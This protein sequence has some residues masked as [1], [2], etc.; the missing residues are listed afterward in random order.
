MLENYIS[1][2][3]NKS[4]AS[5]LSLPVY[6]SSYINL[7]SA[8]QFLA[9]SICFQL[10]VENISEKENMLLVWKLRIPCSVGFWHHHS[11][12]ESQ[13]LAQSFHHHTLF[14]VIRSFVLV[15]CSVLDSL[16]CLFILS[17]HSSVNPGLVLFPFSSG[18]RRVYFD[19]QIE[20]VPTVSS[21][22]LIHCCFSPVLWLYPLCAN[23]ENLILLNSVL[24]GKML[25][26]TIL[27]GKSGQEGLFP[28]LFHIVIQEMVYFSSSAENIYWS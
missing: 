13:V 3:I 22:Q 10:L 19:T 14:S 17:L 6:I 12:L 26:T 8:L 11:T 27:G 28:P 16:P 20:S 15:P 9:V 23:P 1:N 7:D 21:K 24:S 18:L 5:E 2:L 4:Q 25:K